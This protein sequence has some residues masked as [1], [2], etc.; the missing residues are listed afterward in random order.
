MLSI[1]VSLLLLY[2]KCFHNHISASS[3]DTVENAYVFTPFNVLAS[4]P[5]HFKTR[6]VCFPMTLMTLSPSCFT[7]YKSPLSFSFHYAKSAWFILTGKISWF[8][9]QLPHFVIDKMIVN[10]STSCKKKFI[11]IFIQLAAAFIQ[12]DFT[13]ELNDWGFRVNTRKR[14][15]SL[16]SLASHCSNQHGGDFIQNNIER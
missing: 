1:P 16:S 5:S 14:V 11:F 3:Y 10:T 2:Q 4:I 8:V 6:I 9:F 15:Q 7:T 12:S 13:V